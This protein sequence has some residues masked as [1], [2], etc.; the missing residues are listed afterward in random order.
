LYSKKIPLEIIFK[1]QK[2]KTMLTRIILLT[3]WANFL[4]AQNE[5]LV[6]FKSDNHWGFI[7]KNGKI[8]IEAKFDFV[9]QFD[10]LGF[11][12]VEIDRK[13]GIINKKGETIIP[14]AYELVKVLNNDIFMVK[15]NGKW[16]LRNPSNELIIE[17]VGGNVKLLTNGYFAF[18]KIDG[19]GL[20]H[21]RKGILSDALYTDLEIC[22]DTNFINVSLHGKKGLWNNNGKWILPIDFDKFEFYSNHIIATKNSLLGIYTLSGNCIQPHQFNEIK[23]LNNHFMLTKKGDISYLY[24]A[25]KHELLPFAL[26]NAE[27]LGENIRFL[28][29]KNNYGLLDS[30]CTII[31]DSIYKNITL[32]NADLYRVENSSEKW[33]LV[34]AGK[35]EPILN[36]NYDAIDSLEGP[37]AAVKLNDLYGIVNKDGEITKAPPFTNAFTYGSNNIKY[38]D[39]GNLTILSFDENGHF[40]DETVYDNFRTIRIEGAASNEANN[41]FTNRSRN[42]TTI[43]DSLRWDREGNSKLGILNTNTGKFVLSPRFERVLNYP[44][45]GISLGEIKKP[46]LSAIYINGASAQVNSAWAFVNNHIAKQITQPE[47][48]HIEINDFLVD[49]LPVARCIMTNGRYGLVNKKGKVILSGML[50]IGE[51]H[52]GK[53]MCTKSGMLEL[54]KNNKKNEQIIPADEFYNKL[55]CNYRL[56]YDNRSDFVGS[57]IIAKNAEWGYIDTNGKWV[58]D[59]T[60]Q[61]YENV[62][63]FVNNRA[64]VRK[65][66]KWGMIDQLGN[67]VLPI[68]YEELSFIPNS[69]NKLYFLSLKNEKFG[70][71]NSMAKLILPLNY[72]KIKEYS[73]NMIA[74]C[75]AGLWGFADEQGNEI[76][77]CKFR[78]VNDFSEGLAA[79]MVNGKY[80]Y[81]DK[82]GQIV[83]AAQFHKAGNF[84]EGLAAVKTLNGKIIYIDQ[85]GKTVLDLNFRDA[86][87][88]KNG[89]AKVL[90]FE[91]GWAIIDKAGNF[92]SN[93][94]K[95]WLHISEF[96]ENGLAKIILKNRGYGIINQKG[97][98]ITQKFYYGID[99]FSNGFAVVRRKSGK[100]SYSGLIDLSGAETLKTKQMKLGKVSNG[101]TVFYEKGKYGY[102][103]TQGNIIV[104]A[105]YIKA[106]DFCEGKAIVYK[107][108]NESGIIDTAGNFIIAP[109]V[110]KI[111]EVNDG[112][113]LVKSPKYDFYFLGSDLKRQN[114]E[115]YSAAKNFCNGVAP[116]SRA[117]KWSVI[118]TR[119][120]EMTSSKYQDIDK[121]Q[122]GFAKVKISRKI[123]VADENGKIIIEPDYDFINYYSNDLI[124]VEKENN[125]GYINI[126]GNWV[127]QSQK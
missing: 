22:S 69:N 113:A 45:L 50:Y 13:A 99:K 32:F 111:M 40:K 14:V 126:A 125:I 121:F 71:I 110:S 112:L 30:T 6:P 25:N 2:K 89:V 108:H 77:A 10:T 34:K 3:F 24:S 94:K 19:F 55:I 102:M 79:V 23:E 21:I 36:F 106:D 20:G 42:Q 76:I 37:I 120:F 119:G 29:T 16:D 60:K 90:I 4:I 5:V 123:G 62:G 109:N 73:E 87:E 27:I 68:I 67:I 118:N 72:D 96:D 101:R 43:N 115:N 33:G 122:N 26:E 70:Y 28:T 124:R 127:W 63:N 114:T 64:I 66:K 74:V 53:A 75:K 86:G 39:K 35:K 18:E 46:N 97:E 12:M 85:S 47:F 38:Y 98:I 100:L 80:A 88:F 105:M 11:T 93:P 58:V 117:D 44:E 81:I 41:T 61:K 1:S 15:E 84:R 65:N 56:Y 8:Q 91:K 51:F 31:I 107:S 82:S 9:A 52:E 49:S 54:D 116:V 48:I 103:D 17:N 104:P 7:D 78:S 92:V 57:A 83:I 95:N 59:G